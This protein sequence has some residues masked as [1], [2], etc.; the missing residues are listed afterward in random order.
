MKAMPA[1]DGVI[2]AAEWRDAFLD[3]SIELVLDPKRGRPA[4]DRHFYHIISNATG[5]LY[6][7]SVNPDNPANPVAFSCRLPAWEMRN[8]VHDGWWDVEAAIPFSSLGAGAADL[9][10]PW[11]LRIARDWKRP[12]MQSPWNTVGG[13][14][15]DRSTMP[16]VRVLSLRE[17][18]AS[19]RSAV[20]A[21]VRNP[22]AVPVPVSVVLQD[23]RH[24][25]QHQVLRKTVALPPGG[26]ETFE[27]SSS[28]S[29]PFRTVSVARVSEAVL[30]ARLF[31]IGPRGAPAATLID[32]V[33]IF[34]RPFDA[35]EARL[36]YEAIAA[37]SRRKAE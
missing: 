12:F 11:G 29:G 21:S 25:D 13:A 17:K 32:E 36:L 7:K 37:W 31:Y 3:D 33:T 28:D 34:N 27:V 5:A 2:D 20:R 8:T 18:D 35:A 14:Y 9:G 6:D 30:D 22:H 19:D 16:V 23:A 1:T 15:D 24:S 26:E 4:G 10:S